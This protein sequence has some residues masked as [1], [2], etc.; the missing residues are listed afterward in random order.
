MGGRR[1]HVEGS[2]EQ[3]KDGPRSTPASGGQ[4]SN[5]AGSPN[6]PGTPS[7]SG[8]GVGV[9]PAALIEHERRIGK[10]IDDV[11][12]RVASLLGRTSA[13]GPALAELSHGLSERHAATVASTSAAA[14]QQTAQRLTEAQQRVTTSRT[15]ALHAAAESLAALAPGLWGRPWPDEVSLDEVGTV[16]AGWV[17]V[18]DSRML[19]LTAYPPSYRWPM[20]VD[21]WS[22]V[23]PSSLGR[24]CSM[25]WPASLRTPHPSILPCMSSTPW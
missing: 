19:S 23:M 4:S 25:W 13:A 11:R 22:A 10:A 5:V 12:V 9:S 14:K 16:P 24:S 7:G 18:G 21:G 20:S 8:H 15:D 2:P 3:W 1:I 17:R 6:R